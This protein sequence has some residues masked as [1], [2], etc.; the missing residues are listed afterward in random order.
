[1]KI[2]FL[3]IILLMASIITFAP[4]QSVSAQGTTPP[5][6]TFQDLIDLYELKTVDV[7]PDG[8]TPLRFET[9]GELQGFLSRIRNQA[10]TP[11][12][13]VYVEK[14]ILSNTPILPLSTTYA[15]IT[16]SCS[17][18]VSLAKFN[19]WADI[20][21]RYSGSFRWIDKVLNT[22]TGLTGITTGFSL[23]NEYSY[24]YNQTA[25]SV[26]VKGG[27][28]V[29]VYLLIKGGILLY[30]Q[31]VSCSFTYRVY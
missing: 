6:P 14:G 3:L 9:P 2:K 18:N 1:M 20:R 15:V 31:P 19:T 17:V 29:N 13:Y 28:I 16:R 4:L 27:G 10:Q 5:Q 8:L 22:R 11:V 12:H 23:S 30:S 26:S 21:V 25:T 24:P 7:I